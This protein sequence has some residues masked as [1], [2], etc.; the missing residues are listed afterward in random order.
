MPKKRRNFVIGLSLTIVGI[1]LL[2][3]DKLT[4]SADSLTHFG[5]S[6]SI[7]TIVALVLLMAAAIWFY[8]MTFD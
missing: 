1:L 2:G 4:A 5:Q 7:I 3:I 8:M 6:F